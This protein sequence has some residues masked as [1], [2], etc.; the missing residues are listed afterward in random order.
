MSLKNELNGLLHKLPFNGYKSILGVA[1]ATFVVPI[2][3][4]SVSIFGVPVLAKALVSG[5]AAFF[6][7]AGITHKVVK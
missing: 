7:G 5:L 4:T 2:V 3:P 6:A 1:L